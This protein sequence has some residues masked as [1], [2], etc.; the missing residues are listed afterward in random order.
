MSYTVVLEYIPLSA[1]YDINTYL[2]SL[3]ADIY[4]SL[5]TNHHLFRSTPYLFSKS[6]IQ[7][8]ARSIGARLYDL[9][10]IYSGRASERALIEKYNTNCNWSLEHQYPRQVAGYDLYYW[11]V[12]QPEFAE[13]QFDELV[14]KLRECRLVNYTTRQENKR[15]YQ[16]QIYG[17][18]KS[19]EQSYK[20]ANITLLDWSKGKHISD[21]PNAYPHLI[22]YL[23][24]R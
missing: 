21:L 8:R 24:K 5:K 22:P 9:P 18:F 20:K 10:T 16:F 17:T 7:A 4:E 13:K 3:V 23:K 14:I 2:G 11:S 12:C 19:P 6:H 15:L 1:E